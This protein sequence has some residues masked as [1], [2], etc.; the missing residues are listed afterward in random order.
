MGERTAGN[1]RCCSGCVRLFC[2]LDNGEYVINI[3][4]KVASN[5]NASPMRHGM[6]TEK[7]T[8]DGN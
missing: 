1:T 6:T 7:N 8:R 4:L 2:E 5:L 3:K